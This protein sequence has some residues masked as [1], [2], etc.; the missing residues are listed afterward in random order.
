MFDESVLAPILSSSPALV[1]LIVIKPVS[2]SI[3]IVAPAVLNLDCRFETVSLASMLMVVLTPS[4]YTVTAPSVM[5]MSDKR[6]PPSATLLAGSTDFATVV[7]ANCL[8]LMS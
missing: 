4:T 6:V 3:V 2:L 8:T 1:A 5:P 7:V